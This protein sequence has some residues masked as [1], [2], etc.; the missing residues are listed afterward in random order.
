MMSDPR[1]QAA[2]HKYAPQMASNPQQVQAVR[3]MSTS[4]LE[5]LARSFLPADLLSKAEARMSG[6]R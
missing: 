6:G 3:S 5:T 1:A 2:L 4:Q